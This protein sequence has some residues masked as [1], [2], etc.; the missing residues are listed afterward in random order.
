MISIVNGVLIRIMD[1]R[2]C[3]VEVKPVCP[4]CG[5]PE[6]SSWNHEHCF[7]PLPNNY[8]SNERTKRKRKEKGDVKGEKILSFYRHW[9]RGGIACDYHCGNSCNKY[10]KFGRWGD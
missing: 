1:P 3:S 10:A 4:H 5:R 6:Q 2:S 7:A 9:L 8:E